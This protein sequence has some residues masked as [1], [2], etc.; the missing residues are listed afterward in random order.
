MEQEASGRCGQQQ[1]G[2][3]QQEI[4]Q[5]LADQDLAR[6]DRCDKKRLQGTLF[7]FA[8]HHEGGEQCS[9]ERHNE[10]DQSRHQKI[11]AVHSLVEP[12]PGW[13][14]ADP[15]DGDGLTDRSLVC[16]LC[17]GALGIALD[18]AAAVG[19]NAPDDQ[20]DGA[21]RP[22]PVAGRNPAISALCR[23]PSGPGSV[24]RPPAWK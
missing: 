21:R 14:R 6:P 22:K 18:E 1:T 7:P 4:G 12:H 24:F 2:H 23:P 10:Y 16:P 13:S 11:M 19:V 8:C 20:L 17:E 9:R 3:P 5:G 15:T